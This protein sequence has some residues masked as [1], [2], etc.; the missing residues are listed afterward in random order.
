VQ[1]P[2]GPEGPPGPVGIPGAP[3]KP[4]LPGLPAYRIFPSA[5]ADEDGGSPLDGTAQVP[6]LALR[7]ESKMTKCLLRKVKGLESKMR[8]AQAVFPQLEAMS[9]K[10]EEL[11]QAMSRKMEELSHRVLDLEVQL[12]LPKWKSQPWGFDTH[13]Q[14]WAHDS[15]MAD[16]IDEATSGGWRNH[17]AFQEQEADSSRSQ[18]SLS[19]GSTSGYQS[20]ITTPPAL[21]KTFQKQLDSGERAT[22]E[23]RATQ[24][25]MPPESGA[26]SSKYISGE[27]GRK[28]RDRDSGASVLCVTQCLRTRK[29]KRATAKRGLVNNTSANE[30][31]S[32]KPRKICERECSKPTL[33]PPPLPE[34]DVVRTI[35]P[36]DAELLKALADG[37][38]QFY[39]CLKLRLAQHPDH[40]E[41][42]KNFLSED[43]SAV[44]GLDLD[45]QEGGERQFTFG[46]HINLPKEGKQERRNHKQPSLA[47]DD[48]NNFVDHKQ[49]LRTNQKPAHR[50]ETIY[51]FSKPKRSNGRNKGSTSNIVKEIMLALVLMVKLL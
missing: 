43:S 14:A 15:R 36:N 23:L 42:Y 47:A 32:H 49:E 13:Q 37:H 51:N 6:Q 2:P 26:H 50:I 7:S 27:E 25:K 10:M 3:G 20:Q 19:Q 1:G 16:E 34:A 38:T 48:P 40:A 44:M 31:N 30:Q 11:S 8:R 4:G 39:D 21:G 9:R 35:F 5:Q 33:S 17:T 41:K 22:A 28:S 29:E 12:E 46:R 45:V 24:A 18:Q